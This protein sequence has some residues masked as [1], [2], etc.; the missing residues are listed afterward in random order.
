MIR[1]CLLLLALALPAQAAV[2]LLELGSAVTPAQNADG[3]TLTQ[4]DID[5]LVFA[6]KDQGDSVISTASAAGLDQA[7]PGHFIGV[8]HLGN[9]SET[10]V[11]LQLRRL[12]DKMFATAGSGLAFLDDFEPQVD[13]ATHRITAASLTWVFT[14]NVPVATP[15]T[16]TTDEDITL[17]DSVSGTDADGDP[18]TATL[19]AGPVT[20]A[21]DGSFTYIPAA[22]FAGS[23]HFTFTVSDGFQASATAVATLVVTPV[24][25]PPVANS[26]SVTAVEDTPLTG[27]VSGSDID[28]AFT[29]SHVSGNATVSSD[30]SF[31]YTP[32]ADFA[33][34]DSLEA[35]RARW[36][37]TVSRR[38][39]LG[40]SRKMGTDCIAQICTRRF[41]QDGD[42]Q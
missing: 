41:A 37:Q 15:A 6:V 33:G 7:G 23:A 26:A 16:F 35:L 36:G 10:A 20:L 3:G 24:N 5:G 38:F 39:A 42:R 14:N 30:G 4:A 19:V 2:I 8:I 21:T 40:A 17:L 22:D 1:R 13:P 27:A 28:S 9:I 34:Q 12:A 32:A 25:D 11:I 31:T 18:L 29:F